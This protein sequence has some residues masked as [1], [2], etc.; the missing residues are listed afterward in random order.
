MFMIMWTAVGE[1]QSLLNNMS[2]KNSLIPWAFKYFN[3]Y[4]SFN[5]EGIL[6][7]KPKN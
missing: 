4:L 3:K 7:K 6:N 2:G 1:L 5:K